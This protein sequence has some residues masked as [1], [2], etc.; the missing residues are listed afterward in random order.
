MDFAGSTTKFFNAREDIGQA[1]LTRVKHR[2]TTVGWEAITWTYPS[3]VD[4]G[5]SPHTTNMV[6]SRTGMLSN[7]LP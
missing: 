2:T 6:R 5:L 3:A 7:S 4:N 1:S